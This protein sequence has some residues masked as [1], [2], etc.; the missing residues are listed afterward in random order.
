MLFLCNF[1]L[2]IPSLYFN[3]L[4]SIIL[5]YI[6]FTYGYYIFVIIIHDYAWIIADLFKSFSLKQL[7]YKYVKIYSYSEFYRKKSNSESGIYF[8]IVIF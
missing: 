7:P 8:K 5:F 3:N 6:V 2:L 1:L 4:I